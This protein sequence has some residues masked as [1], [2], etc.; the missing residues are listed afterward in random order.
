MTAHAEASREAKEPYLTLQ[1]LTRLPSALAG[2][3]LLV[4]TLEIPLG[5]HK[6]DLE[7]EEAEAAEEEVAEAAEAEASESLEV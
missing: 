5:A 1:P 4:M 3:L 6:A 2:A 7:V